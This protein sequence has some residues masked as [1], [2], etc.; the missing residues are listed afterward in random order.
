MSQLIDIKSLEEDVS[1]THPWLKGLSFVKNQIKKS[2]QSEVYIAIKAMYFLHDTKSPLRS[3][4][5]SEDE[6]R[7]E[8]AL[9]LYNKKTIKDDIVIKNWLLQYNLT[10][11]EREF[12][13]Y[14]LEVQGFN[15]MLAEWTW[16][17]DS[18][19]NRIKTMSAFD[20]FWKKFQDLK[21]EIL[22]QKTTDTHRANEEPSFLEK[23]GNGG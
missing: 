23:K 8:V 16:D 1:K 15:Q 12:K 9:N 7:K 2:G 10:E 11:V 20:T 18:A 21:R 22:E 17:Q 19:Q 3:S 5:F 6:L 13:K 4:G 14:E